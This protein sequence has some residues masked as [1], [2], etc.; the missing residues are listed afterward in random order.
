M[1]DLVVDPKVLYENYAY[2]SS[3]SKTFQEHCGQLAEQAVKLYPNR[4]LTV[5][6][7]ASNDG[8]MALEFQRRG[9][10]VLGIEP[11]ANLAA[12]P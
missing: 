3:I 10:K 4:P 6:E 9:A 12:L 7:I 1:L 8:C 5:W 11:A 2:Q